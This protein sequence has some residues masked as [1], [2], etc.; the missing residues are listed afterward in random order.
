MRGTPAILHVC[1]QGGRITPAHAGNTAHVGGGN[2]AD[3]DHPRACGEHPPHPGAMR[4]RRGSPP[5]M[6]GTL[7][8]AA[9]WPF[10]F[11]ITPA[12]AGNTMLF[13]AALMRTKD[14][15]RACGEHFPRWI[16]A[17]TLRGSPPRMRGTRR[18]AID[19][20]VDGRITPAHAGNT[21]C[22]TAMTV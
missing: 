16:C 15:P 8:S 10:A 18:Q 19:W 1:L 6:R 9:C 4:W 3:R 11:W 2:T 5:R 22:G 12:H 21:R 17:H 7:G 20:L 14:H 13:L